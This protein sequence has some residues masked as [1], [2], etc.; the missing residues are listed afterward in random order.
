[1]LKHLKTKLVP[2]SKHVD[3]PDMILDTNLHPLMSL[4][5][6][7][8]HLGV[9]DCVTHT[10]MYD[11]LIDGLFSHFCLSI[12]CLLARGYY[13]SL[14]STKRSEACWFTVP[15]YNCGNLQSPPYRCKD[16]KAIL[17]LIQSV[18]LLDGKAG[19]NHMFFFYCQCNCHMKRSKPT[20][21]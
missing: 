20:V 14:V 6:T 7:D 16:R 17:L 5:N 9:R 1:M 21:C 8:W 12:F 4:T 10:Q 2:T 11:R 19:I 13:I 3:F 15:V 18:N